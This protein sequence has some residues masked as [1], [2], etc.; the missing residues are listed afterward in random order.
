MDSTLEV[1][2]P[3]PTADLTT[4]ETVKA[5][6]GITG[7][8][9]DA[10][11]SRKIAEVSEGMASYRGY[12]FGR[13]TY[14]QTFR[15]DRCADVLILSRRWG[16]IAIGSIT[17]DGTALEA[18]QYE[19]DDGPGLL[20]RL[21]SDCRTVW[22]ARKVVVEYQAGFVLLTT[23]PRDLEQAC[24]GMVVAAYHVKGRDPTLRSIEVPDVAREDYWGGASVEKKGGLPADVAEVVDRYRDWSFG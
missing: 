20:Y 16:G 11:L 7:E 6:L 15:L 4:L 22:R 24:I 10:F 3:A 14:R 13:Q 17:A 2:T 21:D 18:G 1:I 12:P 19:L 9:H 8:E 23:L 5:E